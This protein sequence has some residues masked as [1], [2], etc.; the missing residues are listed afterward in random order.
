[1]KGHACGVQFFFK[2]F[3]GAMRFGDT[4]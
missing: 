4:C 1:V 3:R 2:N